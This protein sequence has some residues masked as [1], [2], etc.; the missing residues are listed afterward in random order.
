MNGDSNVQV[1]RLYYDTD[2]LPVVVM[3]HLAIAEIK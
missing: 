2:I 1:T 3:L